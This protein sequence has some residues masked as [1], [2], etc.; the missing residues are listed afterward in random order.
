MG[1]LLSSIWWAATACAA[2]MLQL[3]HYAMSSVYCCRCSSQRAG[4]L[5]TH[6]Q[7]VNQARQHSEHSIG[8]ATKCATRLSELRTVHAA[9]HE[10]PQRPV[11]A[12]AKQ[13]QRNIATPVQSANPITRCE[14]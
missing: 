4:N 11:A 13:E 5:P 6:A 3:S 9:V 1:K 14:R 8:W 7:V 12:V 2:L 10:S